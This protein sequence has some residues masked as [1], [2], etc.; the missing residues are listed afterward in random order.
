[1]RVVR[2]GAVRIWYSFTSEQGDSVEGEET[3]QVIP[4]FVDADKRIT[5]ILSLYF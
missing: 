1:V 3:V 2:E 4:A 5:K